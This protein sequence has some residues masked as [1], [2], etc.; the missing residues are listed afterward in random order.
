MDPPAGTGPQ[1]VEARTGRAR[2]PPGERLDVL[3][4]ALSTLSKD[5]KVLS[6]L[7]A[8]ALKV[9][10]AWALK[11]LKILKVLN[12]ALKVLKVLNAALKVLNTFKAPG[13]LSPPV[14]PR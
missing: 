14:R 3:R 6:T 4:R 13:D 7:K 11:V 9:L 5:L 1:V 8:R 12:M 10:E 2:E